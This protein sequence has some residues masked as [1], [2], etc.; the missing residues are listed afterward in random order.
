M[1]IFNNQH[2]TIV[3]LDTEKQDSMQ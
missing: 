1:Y 3:R 2:P